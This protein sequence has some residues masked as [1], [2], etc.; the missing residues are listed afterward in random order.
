MTVETT[1][2]QARYRLNTDRLRK[3]A[4]F[5]LRLAARRQPRGPWDDIGVVLTDDS[6]M[7][8]VNRVCLSRDGAT[9]V[10]SLAYRPIPG[11]DQ[12]RRGEIIV[13]V[14]RAVDAASS[15]RSWG[16]SKELA[17]Y[18]A[19]G[20]D[21]LSGGRDRTSKGRARMRRTELRWLKEAGTAG[22]TRGLIRHNQARPAGN[23]TKL[24]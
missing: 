20:F 24:P 14:Q 22:L 12:P 7:A 18:V 5:L 15:R 9:D 1:N 10:I 4:A 13:N 6:G 23:D 11:D 17:L 8:A 21:H 16:P 2:I 19:H 3:L